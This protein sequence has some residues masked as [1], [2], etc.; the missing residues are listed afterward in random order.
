MIK[1]RYGKR[2]RGHVLLLSL[3]L[4]LLV[5]A[6]PATVAEPVGD[7]LV[8]GF[9]GD[10]MAH[11]VNYNMEDYSLIYR[12]VEPTLQADDLTFGNLEFP[13]DPRLPRSTYPRFNNHPDYVQAAIDGGIEVFS[14]ANNHSSDW[15]IGSIA[16]TLASM[17]ALEQ[18]AGRPIWY[19]GIRSSEEVPFA[20]TSMRIKGWHIGYLAVTQ[21]QNLQPP[22]PYVLEVD[23]RRPEETG[24]FIRWLEEITPRYDLFVLSYHG[25]REYARTPEPSKVEFLRRAVHA[26]VHIV[27]GH[28]PHVLQPVEVVHSGGLR[29]VILYSLG[30]FISGQGT[31]IDPERPEADWSYTGDSAIFTLRVRRVNGRASVE[32]MDS[33]LTSNLRIPDR[34]FVVETMDRLAE[35]VLDPLWGG[36][37]VRRR[38]IMRS[39][40]RESRRVTV[41]PYPEMQ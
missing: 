31:R 23:Y 19:S 12:A 33:V 32:R 28:H 36:Y 35:T 37:Y 21:F 4:V 6:S 29:R 27:H 24:P 26:G 34:S 11:N 1:N 3:S 5:A 2:P 22:K 30:N 18:S 13:V 17:S 14:L 15:G 9:I 16:Q 38:E 25:G 41:A 7:E 39:F 10:I 20:P 8:L 40:L